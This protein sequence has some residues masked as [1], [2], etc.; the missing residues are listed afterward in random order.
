[1]NILDK[2]SAYQLRDIY[3]DGMEKWPKD[4]KYWLHDQ[5]AYELLDQWLE[6]V[7]NEEYLE[8]ARDIVESE[9]Y[10]YE[11]KNGKEMLDFNL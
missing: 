10:G 7:S 1:M 11:D 8:K 2:Y 9:T 6:T 5:M 3:K 4:F